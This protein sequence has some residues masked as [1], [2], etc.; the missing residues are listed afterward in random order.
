MWPAMRK[1]SYERL[2]NES[3][4]SL[5]RITRSKS[6]VLT[7]FM[8][9]VRIRK[10]LRDTNDWNF[11]FVRI[12][13]SSFLLLFYP[14]NVIMVFFSNWRVISES[15]FIIKNKLSNNHWHYT[16]RWR[17][18]AFPYLP[19]NILQDTCTTLAVPRVLR[20]TS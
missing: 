13:L 3:E 2:A 9:S 5:V 11:T 19:Y 6:R 15:Y 16:T 14:I 7:A 17:I 18:I 1:G 20:R 8:K 4:D 12:L 10:I